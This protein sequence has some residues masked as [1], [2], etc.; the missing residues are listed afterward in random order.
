MT[1]TSGKIAVDRWTKS[2]MVAKGRITASLQGYIPGP[3]PRGMNLESIFYMI[4]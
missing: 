4:H 2:V 3:Q 1:L